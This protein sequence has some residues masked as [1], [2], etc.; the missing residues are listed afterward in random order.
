MKIRYL[1]LSILFGSLLVLSS[2]NG[3]QSTEVAE[4]SDVIS[5]TSTGD[6]VDSI[7]GYNNLTYTIADSQ[8][9]INGVVDSSVTSIEVPEMIEETYVTEIDLGAFEECTNLESISLPF[10]GN[11]VDESMNAFFGYIF[12]AS[13]YGEN[14]SCVPLSLTAVTITGG[15][16]IETGAFYECTSLTSISIPDSVTSIGNSAF[17]GCTGF[18]SMTVPDS[19]TSMGYGAFKDC[20]N[21][22]E[23]SIPFV[24]VNTESTTVINIGYIFGSSNNDNVPESLTAVTVTN[25]SSIGE[26]AFSYCD[27]LTTVNLNEGIL[28]IGDLAFS[29]CSNLASITIPNSVTSVGSSVF[30]FCTGLTSAIIS[31]NLTYIGE[32]M[33]ANCTS[34]TSITIP[35]GV[36]VLKQGAF[37][38]C[39]ALISITIPNSVT[40][41]EIFTFDD[42]TSLASIYYFGDEASRDLIE[43]ADYNTE[44]NYVTVYYYS[45]TEPVESG[46]YWHYVDGDIEIW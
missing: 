39:T 40:S 30:R 32:F 36:T 4:D 14:I 41:V 25:E 45:E 28:S 29:N 23:I 15:L 17:Y 13:N 19:V 44:L 43:I 6:E 35:D 38:V 34:L 3:T 5:E 24:G 33:F 12:G 46:D 26:Y 11:M 16:I 7:E 9:T 2:C 20:S 27:T 8:V 42:C 10:V 22:N 18:T 37:T 31:E 1:I 21:L